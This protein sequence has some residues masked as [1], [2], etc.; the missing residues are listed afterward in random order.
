[1]KIILLVASMAATIFANSNVTE[2]PA[3]YF[4]KGGFYKFASPD[5]T[6]EFGEGFITS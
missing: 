1:M 5:E 6:S 3:N 4:K 2:A